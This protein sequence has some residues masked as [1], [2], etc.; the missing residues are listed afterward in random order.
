[1]ATTPGGI[2]LHEPGDGSPDVKAND[3]YRALEG[4]TTTGPGTPGYA[5]VDI[6]TDANLDLSDPGTDTT[7]LESDV[8]DITSGVTLTAVRDLLVP[9]NGRKF[10]IR[11]STTGGFALRV[12][13][14]GG[15][16]ITIE[17]GTWVELAADGTDVVSIEGPIPYAAQDQSGNILTASQI[18][19]SL[20]VWK[21]QIFSSTAPNWQ[22]LLGVATTAQTDVLIQK[23]ATTTIATMRFAAAGTVATFVAG[24]TSTLDPGDTIDVIA[25][26]TPDSTA[27]NFSCVV[28][29]NRA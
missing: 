29:A 26:A 5:T 6:P 15:A 1:M 28:L 4:T 16:G 18:L 19:I 22:G 20:P 25:P 3:A 17:P 21:R 12:K 14:S 9:T 27:A 13:T 23:N 7:M 8:F 2:T 24:T 10:T 11:N